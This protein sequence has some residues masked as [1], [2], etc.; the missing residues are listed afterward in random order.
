MHGFRGFAAARGRATG[1]YTDRRVAMPACMAD[2]R[3]SGLWRSTQLAPRARAGALACTARPCLTRRSHAGEHAPTCPTTPE[4]PQTAPFASPRP[5][6]DPAPARRASRTSPPCRNGSSIEPMVVRSVGLS[7]DE[8]L[9]PVPRLVQ[10]PPPVAVPVRDRPAGALRRRARRAPQPRD[11]R[12]LLHARRRRICPTS[13]D[14]AWGPG[15]NLR[16][17]ASRGHAGATGIVEP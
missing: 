14:R 17:V 8:V 3:R 7:P 15:E 5:A 16:I 12:A 6:R 10:R 1:A 9:G 4:P 13:P 11:G 2:V